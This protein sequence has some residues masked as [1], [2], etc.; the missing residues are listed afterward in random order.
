MREA[1]ALVAA[2]LVSQVIAPAAM[3]QCAANGWCSIYVDKNSQIY[4]KNRRDLGAGRVVVEELTVNSGKRIP[5]LQVEYDCIME[6]VKG[7]PLP[8]RDVLPE[9]FSAQVMVS[10]CKYDFLYTP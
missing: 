7:G 9:T 5:P 1:V 3:A 2:M 6:R 4:H 8:W 10:A